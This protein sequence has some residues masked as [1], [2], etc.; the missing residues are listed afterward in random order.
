[1]KLE[2]QKD[3]ILQRLEAALAKERARHEVGIERIQKQFTELRERTRHP[4]ENL[5]HEITGEYPDALCL[6]LSNILKS[7]PDRER[8]VLQLRFGIPMGPRLTL[9]QIAQQYRVTRE[10][11]RQIEVR[12]LRLCRRTASL[13]LLTPFVTGNW[14]SIKEPSTLCAKCGGRTPTRGYGIEVLP[15]SMRSHFCLMNAG[16]I[17]LE[18]LVECSERDLLKLKNFGR[19]SL[20]EVRQQLRQHGL[21]LSGE[22]A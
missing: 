7:L 11:V 21:F 14:K 12:A 2:M 6:A 1:M 19:L 20:E 22:A 15:L 16:I 17:T 8:G 10:R 4:V 9:E 18:Q 3:P 13:G 5:F